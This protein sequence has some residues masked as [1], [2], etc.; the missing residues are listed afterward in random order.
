MNRTWGKINTLLNLMGWHKY[1]DYSKAYKFNVRS[2]PKSLC[3]SIYSF[4]IMY[5]PPI[6]LILN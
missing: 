1:S 2:F 3:K 5:H 4:M 6:R